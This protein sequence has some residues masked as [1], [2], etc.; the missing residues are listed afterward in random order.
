MTD[1]EKIAVVREICEMGMDELS[2]TAISFYLTSAKE[3]ILKRLWPLDPS[4]S[5]R[6][7]P[8]QFN[9]RQI[10]IAVDLIQRRGAEGETAHNETG[11]SRTYANAY[12]PIDLLKD[13]VPYAH[14]PGVD[15]SE[16]T[17]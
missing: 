14:V 11:V 4:A 5:E 16:E 2:D 8:S 1:T 9:N 15:N 7:L 12:V 13:I 17:S 3:A 10:M 6:S